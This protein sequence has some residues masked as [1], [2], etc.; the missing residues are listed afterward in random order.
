MLVVVGE[1]LHVLG[2]RQWFALM[3]EL[4]E[5]ITNPGNYHA[6]GLDT[7]MAIDAVFERPQFEQ[8]FNVERLWRFHFALDAHRPGPRGQDAGVLGGLVLLHA[9]LIEVV[10]VGDVLKA[11]QLLA[12]GGQRAFHGLK[13]GSGQRADARRK[14]LGQPFRAQG[15]RTCGQSA[16]S[17]PAHKASAVE[18]LVFGR[19]GG[20]WNIRRFADEHVRTSHGESVDSNY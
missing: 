19:D 17:G 12:G 10:V 6:P 16:R 11:G 1:K 5:R 2:T 15:S 13:L 4:G 7:A 18:V 20:G 3:D 9:K 8:R 14:D